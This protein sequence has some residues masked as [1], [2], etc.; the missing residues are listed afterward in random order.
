MKEQNFH[1]F[2]G[3]DI[4]K[5]TFDVAIL[6]MGTTSSHVFDNTT[7]GIRA[8]YRL[9][10]NRKINLDTT[11]ICMEHTGVYGK[12]LI[13]KLTEKQTHFC[14]EM[15][16]QIQ[17]SLGL[18]RGKSDRLDAVRIAKYAAKN[19][20]ELKAYEPTADILEQ[21]KVLMKIREQLI[22]SRSNLNKYPNE[23]KGFDPELAKLARKNTKR[24]NKSLGEEIKMIEAE[25]QALILSDIELTRC[26]AL[27]TS[28]TGVGK[29]TALYLTIFT[30]F[31]TRYDNPKQLACYCGVAPF[32]Y[33]SGI[34]IQKRTRTHHMANRILK[35]QLHMCALSAINHDSDLR[36]YFQRK[37]AEGKNKMLIINNVR[38]KL[39]LRICAVIKRQKPYVREAA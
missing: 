27:V 18:Q 20:S 33:T 14:V 30:N 16:Y 4:S 34:S 35:R 29:I 7:K 36:D 21:A 28:V 9:L 22:N 1:H 2:I 17:R 23:L 32:E 13:S 12:L 39:I 10:R 25:I 5:K 24:I 37:V 11:L 26:I 8:F 31:F 38:N 6:L 19:A 15:G 3:I